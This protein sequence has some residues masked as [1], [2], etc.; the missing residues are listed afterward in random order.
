MRASVVAPP[1]SSDGLALPSRSIPSGSRLRLLTGVALAGVVLIAAYVH[2]TIMRGTTFYVDEWNAIFQYDWSPRQLFQPVNG[3]NA[4]VGRFLWYLV[5]AVFGI[6]DYLPFRLLGLGFNLFTALA[7]FAYGYRRSGAFPALSLCTLSLFMGS[8]FHTIL[9]P[10]S[11]IGLFS[12]GALVLCLVCLESDR[13]RAELAVLGLILLAFGTG[14]MGIVVYASTTVEILLRR[15]LRRWWLVVMPPLLYLAWLVSV[16]GDTPHEGLSMENIAS[17]PS[18]IA[19]ALRF[20][21]AGLFG[22]SPSWASVVLIVYLV[23]VAL[24]ATFNRSRIDFVRVASL[25]T[26]PITFWA[27]TAMFRGGLGEAGAPRY[28]AFGALPLA[29]I[30]F[31]S[32][33]GLP[34]RPALAMGAVAAAGISIA[35]NLP[36]LLTAGVN[37]RYIGQIHRAQLAALEIA[38]PTVDSEFVPAGEW[39]RYV[40]A[41]PYFSAVDRFGSPAMP[42]AAL[43]G[44]ID[45]A[46]LAA[47]EI[48]I[49]AR[50]VRV[51]TSVPTR[52]CA[53]GR[54]IS[55]F[56][57]LGGSEVTV[58]NPSA[59]PAKVQFRR[60][61]PIFTDKLPITV[62]ALQAVRFSVTGDRLSTVP[63]QMHSTAPVTVCRLSSERMDP[64]ATSPR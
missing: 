40:R 48:L 8:S 25:A 14:G 9:W 54:N 44:A 28:I 49:D 15:Q 53:D 4:F 36:M 19:D 59:S 58:T 33:R 12:M 43:V 56:S 45:G 7:L 55:D 17:A 5:M 22:R 26:A 38:R 1:R 57:V 61:G 60:L 62:P 20:A 35:G 32:A 31:E 46:R 27:L 10:A 34:S 51:T 29:L 47:D 52:D 13:R 30:L 23:S 39:A 50:E 41:A 6:A 37:F 64:L 11:A 3:H 24:L 42:L 63:W 18:Y 21:A 16:A 2:V